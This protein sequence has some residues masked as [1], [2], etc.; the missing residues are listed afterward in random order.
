MTKPSASASAALKACAMYERM[1]MYA[2]IDPIEAQSAA[3]CLDT[4]SVPSASI[5]QEG[6]GCAGDAGVSSAMRTCVRPERGT[7]REAYGPVN[8]ATST[9]APRASIARERVVVPDTRG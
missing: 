5:T 3:N 8:P 4:G 9:Q 1:L 6:F 2:P 7:T